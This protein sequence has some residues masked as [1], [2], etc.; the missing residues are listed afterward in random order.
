MRRLLFPGLILVSALFAQAPT[1]AAIQ[2]PADEAAYKKA[3]AVAEPPAQLGAILQFLSDYPN[4]R[5]VP[6][7]INRGFL[8]AEKVGPWNP[9]RAVEFAGDIA[10]RLAKASPMAR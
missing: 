3:L 6:L 7:M 1:K 5:S 2:M 4:S 9:A 10:K 8:A